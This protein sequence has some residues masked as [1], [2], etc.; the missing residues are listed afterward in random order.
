MTPKEETPIKH[1]KSAKL[2]E[3]LPQ[4]ENAPLQQFDILHLTHLLL[5]ISS[6]WQQAMEN[7]QKPL[8]TDFFRNVC[9]FLFFTFLLLLLE[10]PMHVFQ[11]FLTEPHRTI[12]YFIV[13]GVFTAIIVRT[14]RISEAQGSWKKTF[15]YWFFCPDYREETR[16][17]K[18]KSWKKSALEDLAKAKNSQTYL[19]HAKYLYH[20]S[21]Q[22]FNSLDSKATALVNIS[23]FFITA[24]ATVLQ[25]NFIALG[26]ISLPGILFLF[27][28]LILSGNATRPVDNPIPGDTRELISKHLKDKDQK[29]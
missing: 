25:T 5:T 19:E 11:K 27:L 12:P 18:A 1:M 3:R 6:I 7:K 15:L 23:L 21:Q 16:Y 22:S 13:A 14:A 9:L 24:I 26:D 8:L 4:H 29:S 2:K 17:K 28:S 10:N 20:G